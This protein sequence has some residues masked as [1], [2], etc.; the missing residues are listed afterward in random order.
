VRTEYYRGPTAGEGEVGSVVTRM[1]RQWGRGGREKAVTVTVGRDQTNLDLKRH[2]E[3][4]GEM[5]GLT[6][7]PA[8][9]PSP[10]HTRLP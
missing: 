6:K 10:I 5:G 3:N 1:V 8:R 4:G 9:V 2:D 7:V